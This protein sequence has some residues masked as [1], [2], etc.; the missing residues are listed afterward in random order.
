MFLAVVPRA[1]G[2]IGRR[3]R[4]WTLIDCSCQDLGL[5]DAPPTIRLLG[6]PQ[7]VFPSGHH[8]LERKAAGL[9]AYLAMHG[10]SARNTVAALFWPDAE[11]DGA[12][13]NLRQMLFK[14]RKSARRDLVIGST[15][16]RIAPGVLVDANASSPPER[17]LLEGCEYGDCPE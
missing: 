13:N 5:S 1:R 3:W 16:L 15:H 11:S 6:P 7:L 4:Y 8:T 17:Q 9:L 14:L 12:R 10:E 2:A